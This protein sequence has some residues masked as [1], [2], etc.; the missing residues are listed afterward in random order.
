M[1]NPVAKYFGLTDTPPFDPVMIAVVWFA[2]AVW[3]AWQ[4]LLLELRERRARRNAHM[5]FDQPVSQTTD[6][7]LV[8]S[9][10]S[11]PREKAE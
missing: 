1:A 10:D 2:A 6:E 11:K 8:D 5:C 3:V 9:G 7:P 4:T